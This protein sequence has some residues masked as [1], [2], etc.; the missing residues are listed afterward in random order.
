MQERIPLTVGPDSI[1]WGILGTGLRAQQ[2]VT[3]AIRR[4][5]AATGGTAGAWVVG[6]YSHNER[7][8]RAF[9]EAHYL[10]HSFLNLADLLQRHEIRA[11]VVAGHPRHH[12]PLTMAALTAG[13]HVLLAAPP[14][15]TVEEAQTLQQTAEHRGLLLAINHPW[16]ADPAVQQLQ[17]LL[18][19]DAIGDLLGCRILNT[20]AL[21]PEQQT[22]RLQ[23]N[24][25][26]VL[27][28]R[29]Y[30][31]VDL[32]C[33]LLQDQVATMYATG[34]QQLLGETSRSTQPTATT[35]HPHHP[36]AQAV[37]EEVHSLL[38]L[39]RHA[40][41]AQ[42]HDA[43]FIPHLPALFELYGSRGT[44]QLEHWADPTVASRLWLLRSGFREAIDVDWSSPDRQVI[45]AFQQQLRNAYPADQPSHHPSGQSSAQDQRQ[46]IL[47]DAQAAVHCL[48]VV[49]AA[50]RSLWNQRPIAL[51]TDP[52]LV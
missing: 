16:R 33:Y 25:G 23:P 5:P 52:T 29:T 14:A 37:E 20:T 21:A 39:R 4:Q 31:G 51:A 36:Q 2:I 10:P 43:F 15:L 11:V 17:R 3:E 19:D 9:A 46:S 47:A 48:A 34:S 49:T 18:A 22:W 41:T 40:F 6:V 13:K 8:A 44:L 12:Y 32:L 24:G 42:L 45:R 26:G 38:T 35:Q 50:R 30:Q 28:Q 1:G 27:L 7:R